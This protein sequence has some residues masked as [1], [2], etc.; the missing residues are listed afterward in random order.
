MRVSQTMVGRA[1]VRLSY[2]GI[3]SEQIDP[4]ATPALESPPR[5]S[6]APICQQAPLKS[7]RRWKYWG[8]PGTYA[9]RGTLSVVAHWTFQTGYD[10]TPTEGRNISNEDGSTL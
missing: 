7:L 6:A 8:K 3:E 1:C 10:S 9:Q 4:Y 5:P 2:R